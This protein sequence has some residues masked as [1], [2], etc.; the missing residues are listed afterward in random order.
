MNKFLIL[1]AALVS[2]TDLARAEENTLAL[3]IAIPALAANNE[4]SVPAYDRNSH[5]PVILT[6]TSDKPQLIVTPWNSWGD[7][8]LSFEITDKASKTSVA[9]TVPLDYT[10]NILQWWTLQPQESLVLDV[11]FADPNKWEG[12]PHPAHYGDSEAVTIRAIFEF[13]VATRKPL[14]EGLW[15][16]RVVSKSQPIVFY[17]RLPEK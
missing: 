17:N 9:R 5:F 2:L 13:N 3:S 14:A 16:G 11:Y 7:H 15:T 8:A 4:R 6:N 1:F 10:K 12:F